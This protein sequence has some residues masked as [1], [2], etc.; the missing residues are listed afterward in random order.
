MKSL[1]LFSKYNFTS[2]RL[3][4]VTNESGSSF[5][6]KLHILTFIPCSR[7]KSIP[8]NVALEPAS[9]PSKTTVMFFVSLFINLI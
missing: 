7:I 9:S 4:S 2:S 3:F 5:L 8:L 1:E 6:G